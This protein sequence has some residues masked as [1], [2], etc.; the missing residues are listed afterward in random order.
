VTSGLFAIVAVVTAHLH[1]VGCTV[2]CGFRHVFVANISSEADD[3][4]FWSHCIGMPSQRTARR[5]FWRQQQREPTVRS[6]HS[7]SA[8]SLEREGLVTYICVVACGSKTHPPPPRR[9]CI[10][11]AASCV[12]D[13]L[14]MVSSARTTEIPNEVPTAQDVV[15]AME[16]CDPAL[17][18]ALV[19][20][21]ASSGTRLSGELAY[22]VMGWAECCHRLL[23]LLDDP[24]WDAFADEC[25]VYCCCWGTPSSSAVWESTI[26]HIRAE[27]PRAVRNSVNSMLA[28]LVC[29]QGHVLQASFTAWKSRLL[30]KQERYSCATCG[31]LDWAG[32]GW[33]EQCA[34]LLDEP[35]DEASEGDASDASGA[36]GASE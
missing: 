25:A 34:N 3:F 19:T 20:N 15:H 28:A 27:L 21:M 30:E 6:P 8:A 16:M 7:A 31:R 13:D 17:V 36:S 9:R 23:E 26:G 12:A 1:I 22:C 29:S 14:C 33:C 24:V 11:A 4:D 2:A 18:V 32:S 5:K 35:S 10:A